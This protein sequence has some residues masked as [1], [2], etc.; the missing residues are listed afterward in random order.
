MNLRLKIVLLA[1]IPLI[2]A[3]SATTILVNYQAT[4][5]ARKEIAIFE[6]TMLKA[7]QAELLN[8]ISLAKTSIE[9]LYESE[10]PR[11]AELEADAQEQVKRVLNGLTYGED[12]YFFV[13]DFDGNNIVH[14]KQTWRVG[15]NWLDLKDPNGDL[16]IQNLIRVAKEGGGFHRY[17]WGKALGWRSRRQDRLRHRAR[18]LEVDG[19]HRDLHR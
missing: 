9:H 14:P 10:E 17:Y 3:A 6:R 7:K 2:I 11:S 5:L 15:R 19:R 18:P 13:Y 8:Y 16:V 12:G 1:T 4:K